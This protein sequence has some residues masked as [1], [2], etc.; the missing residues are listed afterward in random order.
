MKKQSDTLKDNQLVCL[1]QIREFLGCPAHVVYL[2]ESGKPPRTSKR[3]V[4][5]L[6]RTLPLV[7]RDRMD[8]SGAMAA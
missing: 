3:Y 6:N 2:R 7:R 1:A 5:D 4:V 8:T